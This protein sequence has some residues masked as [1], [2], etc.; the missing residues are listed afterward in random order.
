MAIKHFTKTAL[1]SLTAVAAVAVADHHKPGMGVEVT[2]FHSPIAEEAFQTVII[3]KALEELGYDVQPIQQV[4]YAAG[5][6]AIAQNDIQW[7]SVN[8]DPLHDTMYDN[9]GGN[10]V[11]FKRGNYVAG[12]AQ[13][14]LMDKKT[15][16]EYGIDTIDDLKDPEIA[17]IFDKTGDGKAD[18]TGCQAGWGCE[19]VINHQLEAFGLEDTVNHVQ[20]AYAAIIGDTI[21]RYNDG[22]PIVYY[23]WTPYWV[24]GILVP[25]QD[26][27][28]LEVPYSDHPRGIDTELPNGKNY[29]FA[30]NSLR[31]VANREFTEANPAAAKLFEVAKLDINAVSAQNRLVSDGENTDSDIERHANNWIAANQ[32]EFNSWLEAARDAAKGM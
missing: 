26:V 6:T 12:A 15:A 2:G 16:E 18:L 10:D 19:A 24:S 27:V 1:V 3:Q 31:I 20:G 28:W 32:D 23:T 21:Q 30:V 22:E 4:D 5:Y 13:G 29:G 7:T 11:F 14:Y 9:A 8:W 17:K 25:G